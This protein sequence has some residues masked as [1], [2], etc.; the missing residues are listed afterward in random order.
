MLWFIIYIIGYVLALIAM[1]YKE[2]EETGY[3]S[4]AEAVEA[5]GWALFWP[6]AVLALIPYLGAAIA[7]WRNPQ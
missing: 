3:F 6:I 7:N 4:F 5:C 2:H 1:G